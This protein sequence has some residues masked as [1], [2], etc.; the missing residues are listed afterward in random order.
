[1]VMLHHL[2]LLLI[3]WNLTYSCYLS[4][5]FVTKAFQNYSLPI[6]DDLRKLATK[7][8]RSHVACLQHQFVSTDPWLLIR[9]GKPIGFHHMA[10]SIQFD[11]ARYFQ[12][13]H[14]NSKQLLCI[15]YTW[16]QLAQYQSAHSRAYRA[17]YQYV[18]AVQPSPS[19]IS[20]SKR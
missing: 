2:N 10:A 9:F 14:L 16:L 4:A 12:E 20:T 7:R 13:A 1:M 3:N 11:C 8:A 15:E 5:D 18:K 6:R 19:S 17:K